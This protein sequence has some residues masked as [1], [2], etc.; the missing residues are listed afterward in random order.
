MPVIDFR[1]RPPLLGFKDLIMYSQGE[2]RDRLTRQH[3]MEPAA[4]AQQQ[5]VPLL[6]E[7]MDAAGVTLGVVMGRHSGGMG[8]ISNQDVAQIVR[9]YPGRFVGVGSVDPSNRRAAIR[10]IEEAM[11]LGLKGINMEP[12][13]Y[14]TPMMAD[15]RRLYPIYAYCED[16]DIPVTMM[17]GGSAGPDLS[18]TF[19]VHLDRVLADFPGMRLAV[20]HGGWPWVR[21]ILHIAYRRPNFYISPDQYLCG[22]PGTDDYLR[23]ANGYLADRFLYASSYPFIGVKEYAAWFRALPIKPEVMDGLMYRNAAR[24]LRLES[25]PA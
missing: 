17:A 5:S 3:G 2:R 4:S 13:A 10:Q 22:L 25:A 24:F 12:G 6:F 7:E 18:Y 20:T 1:L 14:P 9:D 16:H 19:P 11:A 23:A 21:E 8:S 15:D